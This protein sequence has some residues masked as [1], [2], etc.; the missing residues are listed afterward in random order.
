MIGKKVQTILGLL[1]F[2]IIFSLHLFK[3]N[4]INT[5]NLV[6]KDYPRVQGEL[7]EHTYFALDYN[8]L[9]EIPNWVYYEITPEFLSGDIERTNQFIED[10]KV[11][12][13]SALS[14][15]YTKSGYDRG[16]LCPAAD[17]KLNLLSMKESFLMSNMTPQLPCFNRGHWAELEKQ[18]RSI[19]KEVNNLIVITGPIIND[20]QQVIGKNEVTVPS[21]FYKVLYSPSTRQMVAIV[22][23]HDCANETSVIS[24][25][26]LETITGIDFFE[27]MDIEIQEQLEVSEAW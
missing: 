22:M 7:V 4:A 1:L 20:P 23:K 9:H 10:K 18:V 15:D 2:V 16:H 12:T 27:T 3:T 25:D 19:A 6:S 21:S 13:G 8:E 26:S 5:S 17:M 24:V 11:S 14:S